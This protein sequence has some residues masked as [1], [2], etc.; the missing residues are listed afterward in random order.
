MAR[1]LLLFYQV[2]QTLTRS[3]GTH[4]GRFNCI[5]RQFTKGQV[6]NA[7]SPPSRRFAMP[8]EDRSIKPRDHVEW[9]TSQ[10][11]THG[12]VTKKHTRTAKAGGH[13]AKASPDEPQYEVRSDKTGKKAI[14]KPES[15]K[16]VRKKPGQT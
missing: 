8:D 14:H 9:N 1:A 15:L 12:E 7:T 2:G 6:G 4:D 13:T 11:L 3:L 16:K 5:P 10:G